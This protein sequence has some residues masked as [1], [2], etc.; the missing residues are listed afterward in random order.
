[1]WMTS[2]TGSARGG[3]GGFWK[4]WVELSPASEEDGWLSGLAEARRICA[5]RVPYEMGDRWKSQNRK[6]VYLSSYVEE[7]LNSKVIK[8]FV[9]ELRSRKCFSCF[10]IPM[11]YVYMLWTF[12]VRFKHI[13]ILVC[14]IS[15][16]FLRRLRLIF[17]MIFLW[18]EDVPSKEFCA[19]HS[20]ALYIHFFLCVH[21]LSVLCYYLG[22]FRSINFTPF[23]EKLVLIY[24]SLFSREKFLFRFDKFSKQI[25]VIFRLWLFEHSC[26]LWW[27]PLEMRG[28]KEDNSLLDM[29]ISASS[30]A[31]VGL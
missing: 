22:W 19:R 26:L 9:P 3:F 20:R 7:P 14:N 21:N 31:S 12:N 6:N 1:M 5:L 23:I 16:L 4:K 24:A 2:C 25:C 30:L 29:M 11:F 8:S 10:E 18:S 27:L 28:T 17:E 15:I 13:H